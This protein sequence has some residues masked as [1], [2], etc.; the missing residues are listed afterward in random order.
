MDHFCGIDPGLTGALAFLNTTDATLSI[1]DMPTVKV[2]TGD[3]TRTRME[4]E[5]LSF[6]FGFEKPDAVLIEKV[7]STPNDG[8]VGAFTFGKATGL[9]IGVMCGMAIPWSET[10]PGKWKKDMRVPA[11]KDKAVTVATRLFPAC[12][13]FWTRKMDHGRAEAALIALYLAITNGYS[14]SNPIMPATS[15]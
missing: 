1:Y 7:H 14:P 4:P 12:K 11:D 10:T 6:I 15:Q 13:R 9:V 2:I 3:S 5:K 8:H